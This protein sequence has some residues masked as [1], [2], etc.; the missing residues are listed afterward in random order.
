MCVCMN[1]LAIL[2][3]KTHTNFVGITTKQHK[4]SI[5]FAVETL[6]LKE[7]FHP[8]FPGHLSTSTPYLFFYHP[9][10]EKWVL[11]EVTNLQGHS[12]SKN[13]I[14]IYIYI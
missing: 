12:P 13:R 7:V 5:R 6:A 1:A 4:S 2:F 14:F 3:I 10:D 11:L 9:V 8:N